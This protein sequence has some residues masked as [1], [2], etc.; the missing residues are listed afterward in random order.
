M[1]EVLRHPKALILSSPGIN[2]DA[3]TERAYEMAGGEAK[4]VHINELRSGEI[5]LDDYHVFLIPGGFSYGDHI[6]SGRILALLLQDKVL[7][8]QIYTHLTKGR[9]IVGVC[10]GFQVLVQSGLLPFGE[11]HP[12]DKNVATLTDNEPKQ[13]Q[14]RWVYLKPQESNCLFVNEGDPVTFPVAH[15]EG[16]FLTIDSSVLMR[17]K[18]NGQ[19]VYQYSTEN[20]EVTNEYPHNPNGSLNAI[21][22]IC[23][24]SG[25][26]LG[27]MPHPEDFVRRQHYSN[28]RR[29]GEDMQIDGLLFFKGIVKFAK[30]L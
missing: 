23:D 5:K 30:E 16:R 11:I 29:K 4:I 7:S 19:I 3:A 21:A 14:S 25:Q 10:N 9:I 20:G 8:D 6:Q 12:L 1:V 13:F 26:I 15:G 2:R 28:W 18:Q 27:M 22:A 24:P 17:L